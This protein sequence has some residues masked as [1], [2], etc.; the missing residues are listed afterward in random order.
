MLRLYVARGLSAALVALMAMLCAASPIAQHGHGSEGVGTVHMETSCLP[1]VQSKFDRALALLHNFWY[2]R[3]LTLFQEVQQAD[4]ACAMAYWG[5]A[6]TYNHPFWDAPSP[7]DLAAAW[8]YAQKGLAAR[9]QNDREHMYLLA[10]AALYKDGGAGTKQS[11]DE[12]YREQMAA[13]YAKYQDDE[14]KLF[15]GLAILG[16]VREG[17]KGFEMQG[18]AVDLFES[19][20]ARDKQHPGVLHYLIHAYDDPVH[21]TQ[22]LAVAR[23]YAKTAAAVPHAYHM[24]SHIFTR[25][26]YWDEAA[27][28]NE[29]AWRISDDDVKA[30][31]E[32]D[33][34]RDYHSLNYLSYNYLQLGRYRDAKK[35]ADLFG[36]QYATITDRKTAPDSQDLQARHVRGRTIFALPDRILYG[37]FDTLARIIVE[38]ESWDDVPTL[39]LV[40]SSSDFVV[41]KLHLEVMAAGHRKD[42]ATAKTK[43]AEM[44]ERARVPGQHP[45]VQQILTIQA[46]EAAA[47]AAY[48]AGDTAAAV[49]EMEAAIAI[50]DAIDS[51]S[52]PPYPIIPAHELYG[53]ML[54][55]MGKPAEAR[56]HFE[57]TLRRTPGRPKAIAGIARAAEAM[58]EA[59]TARTH[60]T[61]LIE[62]WTHADPDRPELQ[63]ARRFLQSPS[64]AGR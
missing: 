24:P 13:T 38:S 39:P 62:M 16:N 50:E 28:T 21:A 40:A 42:A 32:P 6:M 56:K 26:G 7:E 53:S 46:R 54:M 59:A 52:Q 34:L 48:A 18:R 57:E 35:A 31:K 1:A 44:M 11:R 20:Y 49:T 55:A 15:Y 63:A 58:G 41:M 64:T 27:T 19:V 25:L 37:Y 2:A 8:A 60:Y 4:P 12:A 23:T 47:A 61:R 29:N 36:A 33:T 45:F 10:V 51:L 14:T 5:A 22:G 9:S 17:A 30:A 3:A 43:A